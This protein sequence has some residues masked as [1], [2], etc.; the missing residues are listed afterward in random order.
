MFR[1]INEIAL[2]AFPS[3]DRG[4]QSSPVGRLFRLD[5]CGAT[6]ARNESFHFRAALDTRTGGLFAGDKEFEWQGLSSGAGLIRC[7][8]VG[9]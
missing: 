8:S 6:R 5:R 2:L 9:R 4:S 1:T 3:S 7:Y